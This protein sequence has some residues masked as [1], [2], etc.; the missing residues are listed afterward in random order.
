MNRLRYFESSFSEKRSIIGEIMQQIQDKGGR[1]V[2][3]K[4]NAWSIIPTKACR[5]K[6]A[7]AIQY[8][9][10][11]ELA[12]RKDFLSIT[13]N[14]IV[15]TTDQA[16]V[17]LLKR[18][19][20]VKDVQAKISWLKFQPTPSELDRSRHSP[21]R[22][23]LSFSSRQFEMPTGSNV[24]QQHQDDAPLTADIPCNVVSPYLDRRIAPMRN[25]HFNIHAREIPYSRSIRMNELSHSVSL[26]MIPPHVDPP[27]RP[28]S[29]VNTGDLRL[30]P[31]KH[32]S[33]PNDD[34]GVFQRSASLPDMIDDGRIMNHSCLRPMSQPTYSFYIENL[35]SMECTFDSTVALDQ[36]RHDMGN[37]DRS[38]NAVDTPTDADQPIPYVPFESSIIE[39][40]R[41]SEF[42]LESIDD[43]KGS[44]APPLDGDI[45]L[46]G[47]DLARE[48]D[49]LPGDVDFNHEYVGTQP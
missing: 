19:R 33:I 22:D 42:H 30:L 6:I 13:S 12:Q 23:L 15:D 4:D 2:R 35:K 9:I 20:I 48:F 7:H 18:E 47:I 43:G 46:F 27:M 8:H 40:I 44:H 28:N 32:S 36:S 5:L 1:F 31:M 16:E 24:D 29:E 11:T 3:M 49:S 34:I 17:Y 38:V 25:Q 21:E 37:V 26:D 41:T 45:D 10:R 39:G 14:D